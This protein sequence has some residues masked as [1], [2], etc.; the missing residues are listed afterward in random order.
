MR[1]V[2]LGEPPAPVGA[3]LEQRRAL[4]QDL[5]D[6]VW[7]GDYHVAPAPRPEHGIVDQQLA[8]ILGPLARRAGLIGSGPLNVGHAD[9]YRVP[10]RAYLRSVPDEIYVATAV[11][12]VEIV[13]PGDESY[14]K[15]DFYFHRD[16]EEVLVVDPR[17]RAV[18]W[19]ARGGPAFERQDRSDVLDLSEQDRVRGIDW[20]TA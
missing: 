3:W 7:E 20:P 1:T 4:G 18:E 14:A 15:L 9:D 6:E 17:R 5:F 13:S 2:L 10:D 19:Y 12:V 8:E 16:V 11:L